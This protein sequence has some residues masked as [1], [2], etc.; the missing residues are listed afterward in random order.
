MLLIFLEGSHIPL[1]FKLNFKVTN[2][3]AEYEA[4][5]IIMEAALKIKIKMLEVVGDSN[6]VVS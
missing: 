5:I 4:C 6:P 2:N 1:A 3:Q